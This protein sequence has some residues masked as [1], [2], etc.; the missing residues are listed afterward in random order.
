MKRFWSK[1]FRYRLVGNFGLTFLAPFIGT[2]I[3]MSADFLESI[4]IS[5]IASSIVTGL[6]FFRRLE[7]YGNHS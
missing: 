4:Y 3:V 5:L 1:K 2:N 7:K 6:L